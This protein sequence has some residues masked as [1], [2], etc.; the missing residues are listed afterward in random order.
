MD[1][2]TFTAEIE[3]LSGDGI[4][5]CHYA[6]KKCF[7]AGTVPGDMVEVRLTF[8]NSKYSLGELIRLVTPSS[9][10]C[11]S[12]CPWF[13]SCGGCVLRNLQEEAYYQAKLD[14]LLRN[15]SYAGITVPQEQ[16]RLCR[17]GDGQRRRVRLQCVDGKLGLYQP[18]SQT[19]VEIDC[20]LNLTTQL[21]QLLPQLQQLQFSDLNAIEVTEVQNG[22]VFNLLATQPPQAELIT[23]LQQLPSVVA[24]GYTYLG[25]RKSILCWQRETPVICLKTLPVEI[26]LNA[27]L[28]AS[29]QAQD[30]IIDLM[31]EKLAQQHTVADLYGGIGT[32]GLALSYYQQLQVVAYEGN[33][34]MV[35]AAQRCAKQQQLN[36]TAQQRDLTKHPL[37]VKE[38]EQFEAVILD[39]P[40]SGAGRQMINLAKAKPELI[41]YVSCDTDSLARD[42]QSLI[43]QYQLADLV[44]VDQFYRSKHLE[45]IAVLQLPH[46]K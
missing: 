29:Q 37:T 41:I 11:Q 45:T 13:P 15:L 18:H 44:C 23:T 7:V 43:P 33:A 16:V 1:T 34:E 8:Q 39:P 14:Q 10:R 20:C 30:L 19:L 17:L 31:L 27:F 5:Y 21:N 46:L 4:G 42:L 2:E 3:A 32:Y 6:D 25:S 28:Q 26:P 9:Q 22:I 36:F 24:I 12:N 38:L 35:Y 40:R